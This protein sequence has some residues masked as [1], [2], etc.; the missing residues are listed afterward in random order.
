MNELYPD[1]IDFL[2]ALAENEVDFAVVGGYAVA[3]HG[4]ARATKDIDILVR[5]DHENA[6]RLY[7]ALGAFGAPL[8][9]LN[10]HEK[11][12]EAYDGIFQIGKEPKRIDVITNISGVNYDEVATGSA[13]FDLDGHQIRVIGLD[14]LLVNKRASGRLQD[15]ADVEALE[16]LHRAK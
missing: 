15:L 5:A 7:R 1:F 8:A 12:L 11:D 13:T 2:K 10:I 14:A 3:F 4:H 16:R 9:S 6:A